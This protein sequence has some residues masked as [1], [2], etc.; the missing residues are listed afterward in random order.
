VGVIDKQTGKPI[1]EEVL[2]E[3]TG[4]S[5]AEKLVRE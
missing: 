1:E 5:D 3:G 4:E 2:G